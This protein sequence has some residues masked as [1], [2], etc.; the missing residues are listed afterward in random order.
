MNKNFCP[1]CGFYM[2]SSNCPKCGYEK[3]HFY[4]KKYDTEYTDIELFLKDDYLKI[5]HNKNKF[6]IILLGPLYFSYYN[7]YITSIIFSII[8]LYIHYIMSLNLMTGGTLSSILLILL[9]IVDFIF[10]RIIYLTFYN[11]LLIYLLK[12]KLAKI[13]KKENY[14]QIIYKYNPKSIIR[15][16][17]LV[18]IFI[19]IFLLRNM[20]K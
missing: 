12:K 19:L 9:F 3:E 17:I 10:L 15:P 1:K 5:I 7:C 16:I 14:K 20:L 18:L 11:N 2:I 6:K 13:K 8:E 4:T